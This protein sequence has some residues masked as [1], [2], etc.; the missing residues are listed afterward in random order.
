MGVKTRCTKD[1]ECDRC[2]TESS[3]PSEDVAR[4]DGWVEIGGQINPAII[5]L[6]PIDAE[7]HRRFLNPRT[8]AGARFNADEDARW[9]DSCR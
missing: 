1:Y 5:V 8:G 4:R 3:Y 2:G 7:K 6:C 9:A